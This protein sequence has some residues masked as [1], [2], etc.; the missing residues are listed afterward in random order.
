MTAY[1]NGHLW[2][3]KMVLIKPLLCL[4]WNKHFWHSEQLSASILIHL[5]PVA[6][7][8]SLQFIKLALKNPSNTVFPNTFSLVSLGQCARAGQESTAERK[9]GW[10]EWQEVL[11][12]GSG[13]ELSLSFFLLY[14]TLNEPAQYSRKV[15]SPWPLFLFCLI[16][17]GW[18][19][20]T[21][22]VGGKKPQ[23]SSW[24]EPE[25]WY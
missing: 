8:S 17:V 6:K 3:K 5:Q 9:Q 12:T 19:I 18:C 20:V 4:P 1:A 21:V 11:C 23:N 15:F 7:S 2:V 22:S 14:S 16:T 13:A 10:L 24:H 25:V